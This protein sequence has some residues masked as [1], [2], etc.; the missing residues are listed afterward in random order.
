M[1]P[2]DKMKQVAKQVASKPEELKKAATDAKAKET[3][4]FTPSQVIGVFTENLSKEVQPKLKSLYDDL[5]E[6]FASEASSR[7][8]IGRTL[9]EIRELLGDTFGQFL[10]NCVV[11]VLRKSL[12]TCYNYIALYEVFSLKFARNKVVKT[13]LSRIWGAEGCF[14]TVNGK[15]KPAVDQAIGAT[16]GIPESTDSGTCEK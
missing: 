10:K 9:T 13:A 12:P 5:L 2:V 3:E 4:I 6:E 15:L 14:D 1:T 16:G 8:E 7:I 11:E